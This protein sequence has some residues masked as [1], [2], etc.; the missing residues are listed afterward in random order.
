MSKITLSPL[1]TDVRKQMGI[2]VFSKWKDTN[3]L[4]N[5]SKRVRCITPRDISMLFLSEVLE[6]ITT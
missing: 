3:Y 1:V 5:S 4:A 6:K 2:I